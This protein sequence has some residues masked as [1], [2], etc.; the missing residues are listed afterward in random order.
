MSMQR[1][2]KASEIEKRL[3]ELE[4]SPEWDS[5]D[6]KAEVPV[7]AEKG[8]KETAAPVSTRTRKRNDAD[9]GVKTKRSRVI[10]VGHVP[11]G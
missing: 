7:A 10:Y 8:S 6:E 4:T 11:H 5:D 1:A 2:K 3:A 9:G